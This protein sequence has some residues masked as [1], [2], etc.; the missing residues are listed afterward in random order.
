[1]SDVSKRFEQLVRSTYKKFL[2]QGT[3]LPVKT[4]EGILVGDVLIASNGPLKDIYKNKELVYKEVS[5]NAVAIRI[6]NLLA[7]NK[8]HKRC[9]ELY[10]KD[11]EY[12]RY[13]IDSKI[14]IDNYHR[15]LA[16]GNEMRA[17]VLWTRYEIAKEK[18]VI[19]KEQAE[20]L[21]AFE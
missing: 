17:D 9:E 1:M 8:S 10:K 3:I 19:A 4:A 11:L 6:A 15:A 13:Y 16:A 12:S 20:E 21:A 2:D 18:A 5:L 14:F 7:W